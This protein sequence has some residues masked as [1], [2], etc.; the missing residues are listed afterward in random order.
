M[1]APASP[2]PVATPVLSEVRYSLPALLREVARERDAP[3]FAMEKLDQVEIGKLFKKTRPRR[4][5][6]NRQ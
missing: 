5:V 2:A 4:A 1:I 6:K 3:A